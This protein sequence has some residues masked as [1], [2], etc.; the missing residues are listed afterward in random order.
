MKYIPLEDYSKAWVFRH[1]QMPVP[2]ADLAQIRVMAPARAADLW[3]AHISD[4]ANH[5]DLLG[6]SDW[7]NKKSSWLE[8]G[9][10]QSQWESDDPQLPPIMAEYFDWDDNTVVFFCY[11]N[12]QI[13]ETNWLIFRRHWKNFLFFDDGPL[14]I[15]RKRQQVAQFYQSGQMAVGLKPQ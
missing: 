13:I 5:P 12:E 14:L 10:W 3:Q 4:K 7:P 8:R 9:D 1:Q 2:E 11:D 15:G 6:P